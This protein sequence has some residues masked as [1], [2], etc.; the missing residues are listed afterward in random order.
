MRD[1]VVVQIGQQRAILSARSVRCDND[2][3]A[4]SAAYATTYTVSGDCRAVELWDDDR[5]VTRVV[6]QPKSRTSPQRL[7]PSL[8]TRDELAPNQHR[9]AT[10]AGW[11]DDPAK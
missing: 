9:K 7:E 4:V 5:M 11:H 2:N 1:Y 10:W 3:D 8:A 6:C